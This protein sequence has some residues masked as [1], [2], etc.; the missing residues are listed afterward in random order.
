[1]GEQPLRGDQGVGGRSVRLGYAGVGLEPGEGGPPPVPPPV[2]AGGQSVGFRGGLSDGEGPGGDAACWERGTRPLVRHSGAVRAVVVVMLRLGSQGRW[3][4]LLVVVLGLG[5]SASVARGDVGDYQNTTSLSIAANS[6]GPPTTAS[7]YPSSLGV[8]GLSGSVTRVTATLHGISYSQPNPLGALLVGPGGQNVVLLSGTPDTR[9]VNDATATFDDATGTAVACS[10]S[11][12]AY[13][14]GG[15]YH[16]YSCNPAAF[17]APAPAG[18]N[19]DLSAFNGAIP[20]GT[21]QLYAMN[22]SNGPAGTITGGWSLHVETSPATGCAPAASSV[23]WTCWGSSTTPYAPPTGVIAT[24]TPPPPPP[25]PPGG[26]STGPTRTPP[27]AGLRGGRLRRCRAALRRKAAIA[28]CKRYR[29]KRR[30]RC[31]KRAR[32]L[33]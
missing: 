21:W 10:T 32:R 8:S 14:Y 22:S 11:T 17:P 1:V 7:T 25:S 27:C 16:T 15:T 3:A 26:S 28:R 29:G 4:A 19:P 30:A 20:N 23:R 12:P 6:G 2:A 31:L 33:R 5:G 24:G 13:G 9:D 18:H